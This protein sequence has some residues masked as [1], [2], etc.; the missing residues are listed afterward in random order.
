MLTKH[1]NAMETKIT[2]I[3]GQHKSTLFLID[4]NAKIS[5][6][7]LHRESYVEKLFE[8]ESKIS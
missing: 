8:L 4:D 2:Q 1:V 5:T 6:R 7:I 3:S